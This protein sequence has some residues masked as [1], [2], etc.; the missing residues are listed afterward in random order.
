MDYG[1]KPAAPLGLSPL[2]L[3]LSMNP[4]LSLSLPPPPLHKHTENQESDGPVL[5]Q[6]SA[7]KRKLKERSGKQWSEGLSCWGERGWGAW[8]TSASV[9]GW[10]KAERVH[11]Y[12]TETIGVFCPQLHHLASPSGAALYVQRLSSWTSTGM[13]HGTDIGG[14]KI[15]SSIWRFGWS[16][17]TTKSLGNNATGELAVGHHQFKSFTQTTNHRSL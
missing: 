10:P 1:L 7:H 16:V 5:Q 6:G 4:F 13:R 9:K 8:G 17:W 3:V 12:S 2:T 11:A 14:P 15:P